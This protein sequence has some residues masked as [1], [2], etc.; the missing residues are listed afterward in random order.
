M[1]FNKNN[2]QNWL[3]QCS[4]SDLSENSFQLGTNIKY[5]QLNKN[6]EYK[7]KVFEKK[8][9]NFLDFSWMKCRQGKKSI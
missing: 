4:H 8:E 2:Q 5:V 1:R 3:W 6:T 9:I 7:Q